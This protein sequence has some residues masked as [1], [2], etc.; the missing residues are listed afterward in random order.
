MNEP[1]GP[2]QVLIVE[3]SENDAELLELELERSGY[4]PHCQRVETAAEM[5]AAL[6]EGHWQVIIADYVLPRF[7]GLAALALVKEKGLDL[8]FIVVS[9]HITEDTAVAAM[10]A[11]A[12][13]YVMK[14]NLVRLGQAVERE[15]READERR[16]RRRSEETLK[17]EHAITRILATADTL[18]EAVPE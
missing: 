1:K 16:R 7:G 8:P 12:H 6:K 11:G 5:I 4:E 14:D 15:L 3:D 18:E 10:K 9:G 17:V 2:L 13:D